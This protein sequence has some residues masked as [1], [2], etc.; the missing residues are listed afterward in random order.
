MLEIGK[1]ASLEVLRAVPMGLILGTAEDEILLPT[2]Y[3]PAGT[4]PGDVIE[5]FLYTDSDDR[6]IATTEQPLAQAGEFA[7]LRVVSVDAVGAF[8]DWGLPKDL[9][10]PFRSQQKRVRP[11]QRVVVRVL[12]DP[13][14][15]RPVATSKL[16]RFLEPPPGDLREGQAV[17]LLVYDETALGSK[18]IVDGRF[19]GL[20]FSDS[21]AGRP[22]IGSSMTG[23]VRHIRDDGRLDLALTPSG[24]AAIEDARE[25]LLAALLSA[26]GRLE[27]TDSSEP[28][29]IR[30]TLALSKKA[31]KRAVGALYRERRIRIGD[32]AIELVDP[33]RE[34]PPPKGI[35]V[36]D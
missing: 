24:Q 32:S 34:A 7:C 28:E 15:G 13:V 26:G 4:S 36:T 22:E 12:C 5:V 19:G 35:K 18:A 25:V 9:L 30:R 27:L 14:S 2:R 20:L 23:Y 21:G 3:V 8:L 1:T 17:D 29:E 33:D 11:E 10:L 16:D 6:P 31:F